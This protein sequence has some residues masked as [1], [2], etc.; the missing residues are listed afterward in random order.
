MVYNIV[1]D[2]MLVAICARLE[3]K[4]GKKRWFITDY[5]KKLACHLNWTLIPI[6]SPKDV[7][8]ISELC[9]ALIIPG[10]GNDINPKYY[11]E[12]PIFKNQYYDEEYKLDK[13][14]IKAFFGQNKK[15]I[16]ICGGMQSLNV[17][18]GGTLFQDIDN[19]NNTFHPIKIINS[20]F[21]S[22]LVSDKK[23]ERVGPGIYKL[24]EYPIDNFYI[25]SQCSKNMCFSYATSLYLHNMSDRIPLI[26]DI[27][28]PYNYSGNLLKNKNCETWFLLHFF[29]Q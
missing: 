11:K 26:Y 2:V 7:Q 8:K 5:F 22:N 3:I 28:V 20:T 18:F 13:A 17:Y 27:T 12:K 29:N 15:I 25:L 1:G 6:V 16:G 9:H 21:L 10:S 4:N 23:L 19:H 24:P 14:A